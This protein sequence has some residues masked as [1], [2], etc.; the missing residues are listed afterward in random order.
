MNAADFLPQDT[1]A[2]DR[3]QVLVIDDEVRSQEAMRR[4][5]DED[6]RILTAS[7]TA[8]ARGLLERHP[9]AVI[10]CDQRMPG[11]TGVQF[12]R[13]ARE[14]WPEAVRIVI[15]GYADSE[16]II[17]GVNEAGI[18]QYVLKPWVPDHL[19]QTVKNAVEAST[20]RH[21]LQRLEL[22]LRAGAPVLRAR[23]RD[24]LR[25]A[26]SVFD[27]D[28]IVRAAG[29]PLDAVCGMAERVAGMTCRCWCWGNRAPARN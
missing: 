25:Q 27:F 16:D 13:E 24:K 3:A 9:V 15:S 14:R 29:S 10:L 23:R 2:D 28:R 19:L 20:L 8:E 4:T 11:E 21:G 18:F 1:A 26:R 7:D 5:L 12:L 17:A 22:D 6:F